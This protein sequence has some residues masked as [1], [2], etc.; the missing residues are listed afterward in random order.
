[1]MKLLC[2]DLDRTLLPNG[3]QPESPEARALFRTFV[4]NSGCH[5]AYVSGRH[6]SLVKHAINEYELPQPDFAITDVGARIYRYEDELWHNDKD[7]QEAIDQNWAVHGRTFICGLFNSFSELTLQEK[8]KQSTHKISFYHQADIDLQALQRQI[9]ARLARYSIEVSMIW[10]HDDLTGQ[11]LL[12]VLPRSAS[13][14]HAISFLAGIL[15]VGLDQVVFAG[16]SGNDLE[17]LC[18]EIPSVLVA[19][20][21]GEVR[22]MAQN[23]ASGN[24]HSGQL[25]LAHGGLTEEDLRGMNGNYSA[26]ILE[27]VP[28]YHPDMQS[29]LESGAEVS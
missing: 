4:Q 20:A 6:L 19:N 15:S 27:G 8:E 21:S 18:S 5:L 1:M 28:H 17:V 2:T 22:G 12:D 11:G 16:D 10:S 29:F 26:G 25:Y 24:G 14:Y 13:K 9:E 7:W 3:E 23:M